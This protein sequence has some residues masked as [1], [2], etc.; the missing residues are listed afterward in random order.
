MSNRERTFLM[1]KPDGVKRGLIG[2][3]IAR[4]ENK[5]LKPVAMKMIHIKPELASIHYAEHKGKPFYDGLIQFITSGPVLAMVW[6]GDNV[7]SLVRTMM[8]ATDPV[9]A[10]CGTVRGDLA[11]FMGKNVVHGSDSLESATREIGLFFDE[12]EL[13]S[14]QVPAESCLYD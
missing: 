9:K 7:I 3:V 8:G 14:Y 2:N 4:M 12:E 11:V 6:E 10:A 13:Y 1:I 5:G